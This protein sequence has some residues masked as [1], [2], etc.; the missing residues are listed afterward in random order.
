MNAHATLK[1]VDIGTNVRSV[2]IAALA[3][4]KAA[5]V[6]LATPNYPE[7]ADLK[8]ARWKHYQERLAELMGAIHG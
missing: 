6:Y 1:P 8:Q 5:T 3:L 2:Q 7:C 4:E